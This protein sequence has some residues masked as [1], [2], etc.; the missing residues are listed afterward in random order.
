MGALTGRQ[1]TPRR[2][3]GAR[4]RSASGRGVAGLR[5]SVAVLVPLMVGGCETDC[6]AIAK[7]S[8]VVSV[9]DAQ[10]RP[11]PD[12]E[13]SA[14]CGVCGSFGGTPPMGWSCCIEV[15]GDV[16]ATI[17]APGYQTVECKIRVEEGE[18]G[19]VTEE[20]AIVLQPM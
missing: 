19:A 15:T 1:L 18:C 11:I 7:S 2:S 14:D 5:L 3:R 20:R 13:V 17:R 8:I 16:W 12:A 6:P 9:C 4:H 10:G